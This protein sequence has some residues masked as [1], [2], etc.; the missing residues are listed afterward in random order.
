MK[1]ILSILLVFFSVLLA[2]QTMPDMK[3]LPYDSASVPREHPLDFIKLRLEL[4]F[5]PKEGLVKG[6][7][8]HTFRAIRTKVDSVFLDAPGIDVSRVIQKGEKINFKSSAEGITIFLK[9]PLMYGDT[10]SFAIHYEA[11]PRAG[12]YFIG[13]NDKTNRSRKQIWSQGQGIDNRNWIPMYDEMND[14][15]ISEVIVRMPKPYKV[16]SNGV[17][18]GVQ[19]IGDEQSWHYKISQP[20]P[21]YLIMLGIGEYD[22]ET[23]TTESGLK[24]DLWYYPNWKDKVETTYEKSAEMID[25]FEAEI[26][27]P[28]PWKTYSQIP[29]QDFM[30]GA[31]ENTT[32]TVFGD[33]FFTDK[34]MALDRKYLGVNAHELAHQWFGD[35]VTARSKSHHWLQES[36]ATHYNTLY[37]SHVFGQDFKEQAFR[38]AQNASLRA[39]MKDLY[40]LASSKAG[41]TRWY[42]KGASVLFMLRYVIGDDNFRMAIKHYLEQN[43]YANV[44]SDDLLD[45]FQEACG[46]S[47]DW[48]WE[49]WVYRGGE[50]YWQV[51]ANSTETET[52]FSLEQLQ[53]NEPF[54]SVFQM[55]VIIEAHFDDGTMVRDSVWV[56]NQKHEF[57]LNHPEGKKLAYTLF[58]PG[59]RI[60]KYMEFEKPLEQLQKQAIDAKHMIDRLDAIIDMQEIDIDKKRKLLQQIASSDD[61]YNVRN[62]ALE[63]LSDDKKS[64]KLLSKLSLDKEVDVRKAVIRA[65]DTLPDWIISSAERL[66]LDSSYALQEDVL[67]KLALSNPKKIKEYL[68]KTANEMGNN[69]LNT[70]IA[71][72]GISIENGDDKYLNELIDYASLSFEFGTRRSAFSELQRLDIF[73]ENAMLHAWDAALNPNRRLASAGIGYLTSGLEEKDEKMVSSFLENQ[74]IDAEDWKLEIIDQ[75]ISN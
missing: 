32:A 27:V 30:Y 5:K 26:G 44:D 43:A 22:I 74:K 39:S 49:Q 75:L 40:P 15:I 1:Y 72:L 47:L 33:F 50:P 52:I 16:L 10:S 60:L 20:H 24:T 9:E 29:V 23:R 66:L 55:P 54:V 7:V 63:Q 68:A 36:F 34:R 64:R 53:I 70:R 46:F 4:S 41:S 58:D 59:N 6:H 73:N 69:S 2:G 8:L 62:A 57:V 12:L 11:K 31:M 25:F 14:K 21:P 42:P 45:A 28:F 65:Y 61:Y 48:F 67:R 37:E 56:R 51:K 3:I 19:E 38:N 71:W 13:W 18:Q 17:L 35:M